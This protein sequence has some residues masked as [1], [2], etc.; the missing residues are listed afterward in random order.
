MSM[1]STERLPLAI[2]ILASGRLPFRSCDRIGADKVE[3]LFDDP[4]SIGCQVELE[5][6]SGA[7]TV[8]AIQIF[9]S[10]KFLR[11]QMSVALG[12]RENRSTHHDRA[13]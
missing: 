8:P 9:A 10:Q 4:D 7:L 13:R 1:F 3:F 2:A 6:D 5:F 11:R 12:E